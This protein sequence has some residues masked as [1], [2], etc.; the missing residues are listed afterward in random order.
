MFVKLTNGNA[1]KYPYTLGDLRRDNPQTSFPKQ[2]P[3]T[4]LEAYGVYPVQQ[5]NPPAFDNKTHQRVESVQQV[6][7]VWTQHWEVSPLPYEQAC[8]RVRIHRDNLLRQTDWMALSDVAM[9]P[10]MATYRQAL[11][12]ITAQQGFPHSV[13][14]PVKPE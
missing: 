8:E 9:A 11:R 12:D 1:S 6:N 10:N 14:W 2:V 4:T 7:G 5:M 13:E 3:T